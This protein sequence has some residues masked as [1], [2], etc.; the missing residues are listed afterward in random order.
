MKTIN[1]G[2][3]FI[4]VFQLNVQVSIILHYELV[5]INTFKSLFLIFYQKQ[6]IY[7][8]PILYSNA[9]YHIR[10]VNWLILTKITRDLISTPTSF[11]SNLTPD[12]V[13]ANLHTNVEGLSV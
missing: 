1:R 9:L 7:I 10:P 4:R 3:C 5:Y 2:D 6:I 13:M 11:H 12:Y 8:G